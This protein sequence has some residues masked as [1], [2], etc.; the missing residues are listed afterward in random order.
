MTNW[1]QLVFCAALL[2]CAESMGGAE[3]VLVAPPDPSTYAEG[4]V[5]LPECAAFDYRRC[6]IRS[7]ACLENLAAIASCM[8]G[9]DTA[10]DLPLVSFLSEADAELEL[11]SNYA[12]VAPNP[13][14][15]ELALTGFGLTR[16]QALEPQE[17]A[18][19]SAQEWAAFY[20]NRRKEIIVVEHEEQLDP[21]S[22]NV[23]VLHEMIHAMQD[24]DHDLTAFNERY[25]RGSDGDLRGNSVIEGEARMH[26]RRYFAALSGLDVTQLDFT[27]SFD[28]LRAYYEQWLF[29]QEDLYTA[30][31]FSVP[32][33]HGAEYVFQ[34]WS[35]GGQPA[36]RALFDA[37]P[38][39][40]REVLALAWGGNAHVDV[41]PF[42]PPVA[43]SAGYSLQ[44]WTTMG[45]W[46]LYLLVE[47]RLAGD[48][49]ARELALAWR[50][51][52]L[53]VF[54]SP[55]GEAVANWY[56]ELSD[57]TLASQLVALLTGTPGVDAT[58]SDTR[59]TLTTT[60]APKPE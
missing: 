36:V 57:A 25:R 18:A 38:E 55:G 48:L 3:A 49:S 7:A 26:E 5:P 11:L 42:E 52:Q 1:L 46:A 32:Y 8:R 31:Q 37:P 50:G 15:F 40:M 34:V 2:G 27:R 41:T 19:R 58:Q 35:E 24:A 28:N 54:S 9:R 59:V 12:S 43:P 33:A 20:S 13:N 23:L 44:A 4:R 10:L 39:N 56:L 6:D 22:E 29:E 30:T 60:V 14:Y 47:P 21:I 16:P 53:E 45:A 51:D 17:M